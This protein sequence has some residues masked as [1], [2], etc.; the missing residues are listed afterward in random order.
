MGKRR[1][2]I[3][4]EREDRERGGKDQGRERSKQKEKKKEGGN[5]REKKRKERK[6]GKISLVQGLVQI[7]DV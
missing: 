5:W 4:Q 7:Y 1:K 3:K 6:R 2:Q